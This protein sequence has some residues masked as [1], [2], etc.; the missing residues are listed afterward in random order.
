MAP[1][2]KSSKKL[3]CLAFFD[4]A[5]IE[6]PFP[7]AQSR[8]LAQGLGGH[9]RHVDARL[10]CRRRQQRPYPPLPPLRGQQSRGVTIRSLLLREKKQHWPPQL[11]WDGSASCRR[12]RTPVRV[13]RPRRIPHRRKDRDGPHQGQQDPPLAPPVRKARKK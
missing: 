1:R 12:S 6:A 7:F 11:S 10:A 5:I 9:S 13:D 2:R 3:P 4:D 8:S